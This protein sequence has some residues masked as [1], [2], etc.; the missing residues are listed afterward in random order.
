MNDVQRIDIAV[1]GK[2][3]AYH[4]ASE[5]AA[6]S[7]LGDLYSVHRKLDPPD[8]VS[9][10]AFHNRFDLAVW[11]ALS[12]YIPVGYTDERRFEVFDDWLAKRLAKKTPGILHSWNGSSY[13]TFKKLKGSGWRLCVE[14]SCPHNQFQYDL[15][16]EEGKALGI[17]H[18]QD[19]RALARNIEELHLADVIVAPSTFSASSYTEPELIRKVRVN[20]LGGNVKYLERPTKAPGAKAGFKVLMVGNSFLRKGIHY[21]VEAFKLIDDPN[22]ELWIRGDVPDAYRKRIQD[23]R[24]TVI[25]PV[26]PNRLKELYQTADVFVQPSI[27][28]GFGMTVFEALGYGLPLVITENVGAR[29][30]LS[31]DVAVTVPIRDPNAIAAAIEAARHLPGPEF[32]AARKSIIEKNTWSACAQRMI[33]GVY[34]N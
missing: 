7:R 28:E 32:D 8:H 9:K 15:L 13:S 25:P 21:L 34:A 16:L 17:P 11:A 2:F 5:F 29:D 33:D 4:L 19:M 1:A 6:L 23:P 12:R 22:A 20:P 14:R 27:D 30:L 31:R 26:L 10:K 18:E 24:I 3:H